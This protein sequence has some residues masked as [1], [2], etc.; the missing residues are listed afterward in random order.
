[1]A[2][3]YLTETSV[4][5]PDS[6]AIKK[7]QED[8]AAGNRS[9]FPLPIPGRLSICD[10]VNGNNRLYPAKVWEKNLTEDSPLQKSIKSRSSFGLLE[11]PKDGKVDLNSPISHVLT[12]VW[13]ESSE[14]HGEITLVDTAEGH[15][16]S[17]L[18]EVGYNPLVSSRG[19]GS[20]VAN[21]RGVD[22]VQEDFV[23]ESWDVV[24]TPSFDKA[25]LQPDREEA[26]KA[27]DKPAV[28]ESKAQ[29]IVE[30]VAAPAKADPA[31]LAPSPSTAS[32]APA[33]KS[34]PTT[35]MPDIKSITESVGRL[36]AVDP[37]KLDPK[38]FAESLTQAQ[39]L[40]REV[41]A[42]VADDAKLSYDGD[43]LHDE[44]NV[45]EKAF[46][47]AA[48]AP[49]KEVTTL[50][51]Q[52]EKA[53]RVLKNVAETGLVYKG[54]LAEAL[55]ENT[56]LKEGRQADIRRRS[57][58]ERKVNVTCA[59]LDEMA[60]RYN[61]DTVALGARVLIL[62]YSPSEEVKKQIA[63]ATKPA[64]LIPIR[65]ALKKLREGEK[66]KK[67]EKGA[68]GGSTDAVGKTPSDAKEEK[69]AIPAP[70]V[71]APPA[72]AQPKAESKEEGKK[73]GKKAD[74]PVVVESDYPV[75]RP[76]SVAESQALASRLS[77]QQI[78][79][80]G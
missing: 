22:V 14:V 27:A 66:D 62:E 72:G 73:D 32:G 77:R 42:I 76:F 40:H 15:K 13:M 58:L 49:G 46:A 4:F 34:Q 24:F 54:K 31:P 50:K 70:V 71:A 60:R 48:Q 30:Q 2:K 39:Q 12:R 68:K 6:K 36:R 79:L 20:V 75:S 61:E 53:L 47:E 26:S 45:I 7:I 25:V 5:V 67:D 44:L 37:T 57:I 55:K 56:R 21:E 80:N 51:E 78:V 63:A 18:I 41:A 38:R 35:P 23:C 69:A 9:L 28:R 52:Q 59:A 29:P 8:R 19:Y 43:R 17:A 10:V 1:M 16:L 33:G 11:H 65:D 74:A 64:Q 3:V